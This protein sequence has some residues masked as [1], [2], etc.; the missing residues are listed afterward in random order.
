MDYWLMFLLGICLGSFLSVVLYRL[1]VG[2]SA[3]KGRSV[4]DHCRKKIAWYDN[5][6]LLSF[7]LLG[8]KCRR[9][10]RPINP[11]YPLT[12][13]IIG[14]EFVWVYW[15]LK[16][17]FNFFNWIEGW[18]SFALLAYWLILFSG[19]VAIAIYDFQH[20]LIPD[21]ILL[22]LIV[23]AFLRLFVSQNWSVVPAAFGSMAFLGV[24][25]LVTRGKGM[26][27]GDVKLGFLLG[28]VLG[29]P[30]I[31]TA[32]F[33]AFLTGAIAGVILIV[34][35]GKNLKSKIAFGPFLILGMIIA[36]LWGWPIWQG[37][38]KWF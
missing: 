19:A 21:Q 9:C 29:W 35:K 4:C 38:L 24:L 7:L 10:R 11:E 22:P 17:N 2:G 1:R 6:P 15:L 37:Y 27:L 18:Y 32:Y 36:K 28:L 20:Q 26:G 16:I 8:G 12:E 25:H 30:Q 5:L 13:L 14:I 3:L 33:L 34:V 23:V 31:M